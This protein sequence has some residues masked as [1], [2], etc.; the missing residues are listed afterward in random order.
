MGSSPRVTG[1]TVEVAGCTFT[2]TLSA[3]AVE[4]VRWELACVPGPLRLD[5]VPWPAKLMHP[6]DLELIARPRA[7]FTGTVD[8]GADRFRL[9][10]V[11]GT[12]NHYWGRRL[13]DAW[14][15]VSANLDDGGT[16]PSRRRC[17]GPGCGAFAGPGSPAGICWSTA[18]DR[19][20]RS[21]P[22]PTGG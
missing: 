4:D 7:R 18:A 1:S 9:V 6:F 21:S 20:P 11:A 13:P 14:V 12:L 17:C 22:P 16:S 15:W 5:P 2:P 10:D 8:V 19:R 3:G